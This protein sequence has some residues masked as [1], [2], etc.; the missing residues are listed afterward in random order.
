MPS[1][2]EIHTSRE[3][4][5]RGFDV[6]KPTRLSHDIHESALLQDDALAALLEDYPAKDIVL[7]TMDASGH[8]RHWDQGRIGDVDGHFVLEAVR[9]GRL[10]LNIKNLHVHSSDYADVLDAMYERLGDACGH[11][12]PKWRTLG[13]LISSPC[14]S[15][16]YHADAVPNVLWQIRGR[17]RILVYPPRPP[18]V[19][20]QSLEGIC[21]G[22]TKE[23]IP[24][25]ESFDAGADVLEL[26]AG[27]ALMWPHHAPH[28]V[29]NLD[30]LN[31]SLTTE[32]LT[33]T[34]RRRVR[35]IRSNRNYRRLLG[36]AA[37]STAP[38]GL[39][40]RA[41]ACCAIADSVWT[42]LRR[43][44]QAVRY[45]QTP[46]FELDPARAGEVRRLDKPADDLRACEASH[47]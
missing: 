32:H 43:G 12:V 28:R 4:L 46:L 40:A 39:L 9:R 37:R 26:E 10:W 36:R 11:G 35:V 7:M 42:R 47:A 3:G 24:Y 17:K 8:A 27:Q 19:S 6:D 13:M 23:E 2:L 30:S 34:A 5:P 29:V 22:D 44:G 45:D 16:P 1:S 33:P 41:K 21:A 14:A 18:F 38:H 31:I 15:V 25:D 20:A